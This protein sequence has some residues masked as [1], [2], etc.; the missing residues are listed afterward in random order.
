MPDNPDKPDPPKKRPAKAT[1][2]EIALRVE[3]VLRIRLDGAQFHDIV[4]YAAE[5]E[6]GLKERQSRWTQRGNVVKCH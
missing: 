2:A 6:W 4:Q 5:K 1:N 3:E